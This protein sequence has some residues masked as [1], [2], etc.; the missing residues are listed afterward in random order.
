MARKRAS[1]DAV[2]PKPES[3]PAQEPEPAPEEPVK[4]K[5]VGKKLTD[6]Q[7]ADLKNHMDK[8]KDLQDLTPSQR[9]SHRMKMMSRMLQG[10]SLKEAHKEIMSS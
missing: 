7:K 6:K 4:K 9:K 1:K 3:E 8:H 2:A 10:K 5:R